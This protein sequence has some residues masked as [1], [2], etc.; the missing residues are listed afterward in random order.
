M[1]GVPQEPTAR[2]LDMPDPD[3]VKLLND[4]GHTEQAT[5]LAAKL[6]SDQSP[7]DPDRDQTKLSGNEQMNRALRQAGSR[8]TGDINADLRNARGTE[9]SA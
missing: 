8:G 7:P 6:A 2:S 9:V 3:L 1:R 4:A 5:S